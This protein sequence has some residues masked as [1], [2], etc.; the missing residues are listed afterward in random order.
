MSKR[1]IREARFRPL[2][3]RSFSLKRKE[4]KAVANLY[5][6]VGTANNVEIARDATGVVGVT[7]WW[8]I[9][10]KVSRAAAAR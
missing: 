8:R 6:G 9:I 3:Y 5:G 1:E 10:A 2:H 4:E 7:E